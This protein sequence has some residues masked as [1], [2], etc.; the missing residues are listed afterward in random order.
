M[1]CLTNAAQIVALAQQWKNTVRRS[2][3]IMHRLPLAKHQ[4]SGAA[5]HRMH[6][7]SSR[8]LHPLTPHF[9]PSSAS[10]LPFSM[11]ALEIFPR[12]SVALMAFLISPVLLYLFSVT[13]TPVTI[14]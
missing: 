10:R 13:K 2:I 8:S 5:V 11:A 3:N 6:F 1:D 4:G 9:S 12:P 7:F 14:T